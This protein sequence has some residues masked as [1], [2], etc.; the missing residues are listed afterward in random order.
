MRTLGVEEHHFVAETGKDKGADFFIADVGGSRTTRA[1]WVPYFDDVDAI[2]FL[3]PLAF[4]QMLEEDPRVNRLEDSLSLWRQI[5]E[6]KLLA[7]ATI[8]LFLNKVGAPLLYMTCLMW[9]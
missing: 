5:C 3:A 6:N 7:H 1:S 9:L 2:L 8:I 4:H